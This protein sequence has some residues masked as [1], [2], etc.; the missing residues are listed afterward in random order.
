[1][2]FRSDGRG[3]V[4][5]NGKAGKNARPTFTDFDLNKDG[6]ITEKEFIEARTA[7]ISERAQEGR[8]MKGLANISS[9]ADIDTNNDGV[10]S[11]EEFAAQQSTHRQS[12]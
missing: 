2:L 12:K 8:Q 6:K 4:S 1:M 11:P 10:I 5:G 9:F 7:R 3:M